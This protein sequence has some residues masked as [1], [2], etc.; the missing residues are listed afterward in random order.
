MTQDNDNQDRRL[1]LSTA[2]VTGSALAAMSGALVASLAGTTGT[3]IGA[4]VGSVIATVGATMYTESLRR[5]GAAAKKTAA[6]V[7]HR[8]ALITGAVPRTAA[9]EQP[10]HRADPGGPDLDERSREDGEPDEDGSRKGRW[11]LPWG[12]V[13]IA[14]LA[15]MVAGLAGITAV[16]ALT[17][18]PVSSMLGADD[19]TGH[20]RGPRRRR[21][22]LRE[23]GARAERRTPPRPRSPSPRRSPRRSP[24]RSP[25]HRRRRR[26]RTRR[27]TPPRHPTSP[28]ARNPPRRTVRVGLPT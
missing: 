10:Q 21:R 16:E 11:D 19:G 3:V 17:G 27:A 1:W 8:G 25:R 14:S 23:G 6:V 26:L 18:E 22:L 24:P 2:Q 5:T 9:D 15:V 4:A 20:H 28:R 12:K 13:A 7:R